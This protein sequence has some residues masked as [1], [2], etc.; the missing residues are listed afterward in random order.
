MTKVSKKNDTGSLTNMKRR[1]PNLKVGDSEAFDGGE[2]WKSCGIRKDG[3]FDKCGLWKKR[4]YARKGA[5][6]AR[7]D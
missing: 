2:F 1:G 4:P 5:N 6:D 3:D 7:K